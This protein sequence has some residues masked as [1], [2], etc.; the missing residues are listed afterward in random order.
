MESSWRNRLHRYH[1]DAHNTMSIATPPKGF[2]DLATAYKKPEH[3]FVNI[4]G[5]VVD[6]MQPTLA[7]S[8]EHTITFKLLDYRL[9]MALEGSQGLTCRSFKSDGDH[10]PK[11]RNIGDVVLFRN[12]KIM[13]WAGARVAM[14]HFS[15]A[16]IVFP[17]M[18]IPDRS[19]AIAYVNNQKVERLGIPKDVDNFNLQEQDY[20]IRIK[21]DMRPRVNHSLERVATRPLPQDST[22]E[23][24]VAKRAK[25]SGGLSS[26]GTKFRLIEDLRDW[27]FADLV[28]FVVKCHT[29]QYGCDLYITDYTANEELRA[30]AAPEDNPCSE[31]DG[32]TFGYNNQTM[33]SWP[34][35]YGHL[36]MKINVKPPHAAFATNNVK[37]G[38]IVLLRNVKRRISGATNLEG[39]MWPER[40]DPN[41]IKIAIVNDTSGP[42]CQSMIQRKE[43]YWKIRAAKTEA[44]QAAEQKRSKN[45]KKREK[46]E[47]K[48]AQ[49]GMRAASAI[50]ANQNQHVRCNHH[51]GLSLMTV[52]DVQD[53]EN[54]W[55]FNETPAGFSYTLPFINARY[56]TKVR[57]VDYHPKALEDFA[58]HV[59]A[60]GSSLDPDEWIMEGSPKYQWCFS[61][62]LE[63]AAK[64]PKAEE[65]QLW[66]HVQHSE[67]QFLLGDMPDPDDLQ[68]RPELLRQLREKLFILW[69][70]LEEKSDGDALSNKP[71]QCLLEEY[72]IEKDSDDPSW[73]DGLESRERWQRM[74]RMVG[75]TI[76]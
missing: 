40:E 33:K 2:V 20:V 6:L 7:R 11:V 44:G 45:Q 39:D 14:S 37:E 42:E 35:P 48:A 25:V 65:D 46:K 36:V 47:R 73:H 43:K 3:T 12:I 5:V 32:D 16:C 4:I 59:G 55:H 76:Q 54:I 56:C 74:Y 24:P 70:N 8:G 10:L 68:H 13:T 21:E 31:R 53:P 26:F 52:R 57:V 64:G 18:A 66:A 63:D 9:S 22:T 1:I 28:G 30:Y 69:G 27:Q 38:C 51:E 67:A 62:L 19:F 17:G 15:T 61:L 75:T 34:G 29:A 49:A 72:G 71:F 60:E 58:V 50:D 41:R 23:L